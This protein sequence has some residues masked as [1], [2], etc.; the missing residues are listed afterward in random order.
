VP[1]NHANFG[2]GTLVG[3]NSGFLQQIFRPAS[4]KRPRSSA[5]APARNAMW[6]FPSHWSLSRIFMAVTNETFKFFSS[7]VCG[8]ATRR[9]LVASLTL[10]AAWLLWP[11]VARPLLGQAGSADPTLAWNELM[12]Q[13][14]VAGTLGNPQAQR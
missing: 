3:N 8:F 13:A 11:P 12:L 10:G 6:R 4:S 7:S 5:C 14:I 1:Q 9:R 2:I